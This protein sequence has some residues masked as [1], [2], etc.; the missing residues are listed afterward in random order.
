M[1]V[2]CSVQGK[3]LDSRFIYRGGGDST[4][5]K[6]GGKGVFVRVE[7]WLCVAGLI[8]CAMSSPEARVARGLGS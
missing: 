7:W 8:T 6:S 3:G 2:D 4:T 1:P 5:S